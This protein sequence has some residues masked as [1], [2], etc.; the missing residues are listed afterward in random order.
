MIGAFA[1]PRP[2]AVGTLGCYFA[3]RFVSSFAAVFFGIILLVG[4]VD[5][6]ELMRHRG[7]DANVTMFTIVQIS[8]FRVPQLGEQIMPFA[9][10]IAAMSCFLNLSRRLELVIARA[11]GMSAWQFVAPV[12]F[13]AGIV[14]M[15]ATTVYNPGAAMLQEKSKRLEVQAF[16]GAQSG[17]QST[18][19]GFWL[20]QKSTDGQSIINA[21]TSS[22]QGLRLG[23]VT[24]FTFDQDGHFHQRI[25][26][27]KAVLG[28]GF[29][30]LEDARIYASHI[31][32]VVHKTFSLKT[33]LTT[34]QVRESFATPE[35]VPFWDLPSYIETAEGAGLG[36]ARYELQYQKLLAR[37]FLLAAMVLVAAASSLRFFR[38][39]GVQKMVLAGVAAGFLLYI[40]SKITEDL[41]KALLMPPT[42]AAWTPA[43]VGAL[44]GVVALLHQEDG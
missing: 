19:A 2:V 33:N 4:L 9:V 38:F 34:A 15:L 25:E 10:L 6:I 3:Q 1:I 36:A 29:W 21:I 41:S 13:S 32:P 39:G 16:G 14:G 8:F 7:G 27:S 37:P 18:G 44:V 5:C 12:L 22:E 40:L 30:D 11:A 43:L 20:R 42:A 24:I 31:P 35:A 26:A 17:L 28:P 23:G